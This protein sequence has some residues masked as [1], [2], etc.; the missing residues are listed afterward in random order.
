MSDRAIVNTLIT[1]A[2]RRHLEPIGVRR[3]G[4]YRSW[5]EDRG[6]W[7][8]HVCFDSGGSRVGTYLT[9]SAMWLW[10]EGD[11]WSFDNGDRVYW[12]DDGTFATEVAIGE[13]GWT[14]WLGFIR[15]HLFAKDVEILVGIARQRVMQLREQF[16]DPCSVFASLSGRSTRIGEDPGWHEYNTGAAAAL[17]GDLAAA[18][19]AFAKVVARP[20]APGW[21]TDRARLAADLGVRADVSELR[22]RVM[23][24]IHARRQRLGLPALEQPLADQGNARSE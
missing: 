13:R 5:F 8:I 1:Q 18:R 22:D 7:V 2:A 12:R 23:Q 15:E 19:D 17:C 24:L 21:M 20:I 6:W 3:L 11:D 14:T 10:R 4:R 9:A 16:P